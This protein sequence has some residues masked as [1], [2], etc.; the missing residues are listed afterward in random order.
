MA[1]LSVIDPLMFGI[2]MDAG[3][4]TAGGAPEEEQP[5]DRELFPVC[6][7]CGGQVG[8]FLDHGL[9]WHHS[10]TTGPR[11]APRRSTTPATPPRSPGA[12]PTR[13]RK[14]RNQ[15]IPLG[16]SAGHRDAARVQGAPYP[17]RWCCRAADP[18]PPSGDGEGRHA[19]SSPVISPG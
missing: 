17:L 2:A 3:V 19:A 1:F 8:I 14:S 10:A 13:N 7:R 5:A 9:D 18:P 15:R 4:Q 6:R 11:P 16:T 12:S